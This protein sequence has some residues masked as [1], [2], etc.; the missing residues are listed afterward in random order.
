MINTSE[1]LPEPE[2]I[3]EPCAR[4][5]LVKVEG[6]G[7]SIAM[8]LIDEGICG[9]YTSY[10]SKIIKPVISWMNIEDENN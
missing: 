1:R 9:W 8:Y 6:F 2:P 5:Y 3:E 10:I 4:R 7:C